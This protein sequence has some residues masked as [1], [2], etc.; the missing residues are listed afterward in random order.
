MGSVDYSGT[1]RKRRDP[2]GSAWGPTMNVSSLT[3]AG[4]GGMVWLGVAIQGAQVARDTGTPTHAPFV[5]VQI[6]HADSGKLACNNVYCDLSAGEYIARAE[7]GGAVYDLS[8]S[9]V[10]TK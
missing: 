3:L 2:V 6:V 8:F 5:S 7:Y 10:V 9:V 4:V 1:S